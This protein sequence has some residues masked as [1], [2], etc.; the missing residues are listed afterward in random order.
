MRVLIALASLLAV[1]AFAPMGRTA[2]RNSAISM[3]GSGLI[4]AATE[5]GGF[6]DPIGLSKGKSE[7]TLNWYRAAE[8]KHGRVCMLAS[9]GIW[10]Q[11]APE[12]GWIPGFV[13]KDT[14]ALKAASE[15][16]EK[17]PGAVW[18]ILIAIAAVEV[19]NTSIE[20]KGGRPGDFGWDP[21][22]IRPKDDDK[23][24]ELQ[25][26]EL[27]NGRLAMLGAAGMLYQ[28]ALT[29]QGVFEQLAA[30]HFSPFGDGQGAF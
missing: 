10:I 7:E 22:N 20:S 15:V 14:N 4:G 9:L 24:D 11:G 1:A 21:A 25:L 13:T 19:L 17:A 23:L 8:L 30:G 26:K 28:N 27:K 12:Q 6:W 16:Y 18:Q 29:G 5:I 3:D 2:V